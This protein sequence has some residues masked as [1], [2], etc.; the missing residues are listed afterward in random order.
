MNEIIVFKV[1]QLSIFNLIKK[2]YII[3]IV[4]NFF[5]KSFIAKYED[6]NEKLEVYLESAL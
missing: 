6:S 3:F 2:L 5:L 4:S 1:D